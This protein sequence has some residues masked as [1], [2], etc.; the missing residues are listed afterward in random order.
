MGYPTFKSF[1]AIPQ[2]NPY[3]GVPFKEGKVIER[4]PLLPKHLVE[5]TLAGLPESL[6]AFAPDLEALE[7]VR[8]DAR[9]KG[10]PLAVLFTSKSKAPP[11]FRAVAAELRG[12]AAFV[13]AS[14]SDAAVAESLFGSSEA[15]KKAPALFVETLA[16]EGEG[17]GKGAE[18]AKREA[19]KA[20][21]SS[22]SSSSSSTSAARIR[23]AGP[24]TSEAMTLFLLPHAL[25][26]VEAEGSDDGSSASSSSSSS[27]FAD[28]DRATPKVVEIISDEASLDEVLSR[29][30]A[31][32][33][34]FFDSK[35][36]GE[37]GAACSKELE[38]FNAAA[39]ELGPLARAAAVDVH[40]ST[41]G[42]KKGDSTLP[43]SAVEQFLQKP[44]GGPVDGAAF[45][46]RPCDLQVV[47]VPAGN[48]KGE[49]DEWTLLKAP[50]SGENKEKKETKAS[51]GEEKKE[52]KEKKKETASASASPPWASSRALSR[53]ITATFPPAA[54]PV[55]SEQA[56][57]ALMTPPDAP[58]RAPGST[59]PP[60]LRPVVLL[61]SDKDTV[62]PL[63]HALAVNFGPLGFGVGV[64]P[65]AAEGMRKQFRVEKVPS[66]A[67]AYM[68]PPE[69]LKKKSGGGGGGSPP[70]QQQEGALAVQGYRGPIR[71][72]LLDSWLRMA[73]PHVGVELPEDATA[74]AA[75]GLLRGGG[76]GGSSA[77]KSVDD[78]ALPELRQALNPG[79]LAK[80]CPPESKTLCVVVGLRGGA[81]PRKTRD[82][83]A[84]LAARRVA[85][86]WSGQPL[87][88][89]AVDAS[90]STGGSGRAALSALGVDPDEAPTAEVYSPA[91]LRS[92][93]MPSSEADGAPQRLSEKSLNA[94]LDSVFTGRAVTRPVGS[95]PEIEKEAVGGGGDSDDDDDDNEKTSSSSA[96][97]IDVEAALKK[98][99]RKESTGSHEEL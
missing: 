19:K 61:F 89:C 62:P 15:D 71:Y 94:L 18:K 9:E 56:M 75:A 98:S 28:D 45:A 13:A 85:A 25:S 4:Q 1:G 99:L 63:M 69:M 22:S 64:V 46:Q 91:K 55:E 80:I 76:G 49:P 92:I 32:L 65:A 59:A 66:L 20:K 81:D 78:S 73:A 82:A 2:S 74:S 48:D 88:F 14:S 77:K 11:L 40:V 43:A 47:G 5:A 41:P 10:L 50:S 12:R 70:P 34:A 37:Q 51:S 90:K 3:T 30:S 87:S 33:L 83:E 8:A 60:K 35:G 36:G 72:A 21:A 26:A 31:T 93:P 67:L 23:H 58:P 96:K 17:E 6:A 27:A 52:K 29:P 16:S 84:L 39:V 44:G 57:A 53:F 68:P 54:M 7:K 79:D 86:A 97:T 42:K 95:R 38:A 24:L